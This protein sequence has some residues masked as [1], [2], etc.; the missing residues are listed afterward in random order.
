[1]LTSWLRA[2]ARRPLKEA[3]P[4]CVQSLSMAPLTLW[5]DPGRA[6]SRGPGARLPPGGRPTSPAPCGVVLGEPTCGWLGRLPKTRP[7]KSYQKMHHRS[8][9]G[10]AANWLKSLA[11]RHSCARRLPRRSCGALGWHLGNSSEPGAA[12][13]SPTAAAAAPASTHS[14]RQLLRSQRGSVENGS[15]Q[16]CGEASVTTR[17]AHL[18]GE[19]RLGSPGRWQS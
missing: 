16:H 10:G 3:P 11:S 4:V 12:A 18:R 14:R 5:P 8:G 15:S 2:D 7:K 19:Q 1:M 13:A 17:E 9:G 6:G